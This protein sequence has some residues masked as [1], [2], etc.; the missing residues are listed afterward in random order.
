[1]RDH[2][3]EFEQIAAFQAG[4][5]RVG[6]RRPGSA[7]EPFTDQF[8]S[9]NYF[10]MFGLRPFA[11]RLLTPADDRP[12]AAPVVV[13]SYRAWE[14][15]YGSDPGVI[16]ATFIVDGA[17][18]T[19]AGIGLPASS[20]T[21]SSPIRLISGFPSPPSRTF[22]SAIRCST[23]TISTGSTL[24]AAFR[25]QHPRRRWNRTP[26][27]SYGSGSSVTI[28]RARASCGAISKASTSP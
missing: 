16:G 8:V 3:P 28:R 2:T 9:G 7:S 25:P 15:H 19:V 1:L 21:R 26:M 6:V 12:G 22:V 13:M 27:S 20:A 23:A 17:P 18:M 14:Q 24:S 4:P 10:S 5:S 11:G